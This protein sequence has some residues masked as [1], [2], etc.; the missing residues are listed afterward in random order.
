[1]K[2]RDEVDSAISVEAVGSRSGPSKRFPSGRVCAYYGCTTQ[3]SIYN[4][5]DYCSLHKID[6]TFRPRG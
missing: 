6:A 4:E 1:V 2:E 5:S 3:L